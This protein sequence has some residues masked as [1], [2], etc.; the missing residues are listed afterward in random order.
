M[1]LEGIR[2]WIGEVERKLGMRTRV[3]LVLAALAIGGAGAAT[4][5]AL[6]TRDAAVSEGDVRALQEDLE[7]QIAGGGTATGT[8]LTDLEAELREL[9]A[10]VAELEVGP[11]GAG[12]GATGADPGVAPPPDTSGALPGAAPGADAGGIATDGDGAAEERLRGLFDEAKERA[13]AV[14]QGETTAP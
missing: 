5:L 6:D 7:T 10:K 4:Y 12:S 1:P 9:E 2:A 11:K 3:F 13:G 14:E 8:S